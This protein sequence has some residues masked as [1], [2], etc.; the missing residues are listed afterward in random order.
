[1]GWFAM[2][3]HFIQCPFSNSIQFVL[4]ILF[5]KFTNFSLENTN[6]ISLAA[7]KKV[8]SPRSNLCCKFILCYLELMDPKQAQKKYL[9]QLDITCRN[10]EKFILLQLKRVVP[11]PSPPLAFNVAVFWGCFFMEVLMY[12]GGL[13][14]HHV[15]SWCPRK[16]SIWLLLL[17]LYPLSEDRHSRLRI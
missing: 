13:Q 11:P 5:S 4:K 8:I 9:P 17:F 1:M 14:I 15:V 6:E 12:T 16:H 7:V 3:L 2:Q 10:L